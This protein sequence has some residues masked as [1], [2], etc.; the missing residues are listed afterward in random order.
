MPHRLICYYLVF[1]IK[2]V[3]EGQNLTLM[4]A[5]ALQYSYLTTTPVSTTF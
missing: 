5:P 3:S 1:Q 2:L 4:E